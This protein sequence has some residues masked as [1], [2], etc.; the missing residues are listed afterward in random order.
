MNTHKSLKLRAEDAEDIGVIAAVM[1]DAIAPVTE[2]L[3]QPEAQNF[4]MVVH[5][6]RWD[7]C[8][9][10]TTSQPK[11]DCFERIACAMDIKGVQ[12]VQRNNI[13]QTNPNLMLDLLTL[14]LAG[15]ELQIIFAG[16]ARLKLRLATGWQLHL[17]DFGD[18][19]PTRNAPCHTA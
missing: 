15:D 14:E 16:D 2:M 5:R 3:F 7:E 1:Q 9:D 11:Q 19:W 17:K 4:I 8:I 6:F 13:D 18:P 10:V 12:A